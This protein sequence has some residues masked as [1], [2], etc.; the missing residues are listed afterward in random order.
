MVV[1]RDLVLDSSRS[2]IELKHNYELSRF[3]SPYTAHHVPPLSCLEPSTPAAFRESTVTD[4]ADR[5]HRHVYAPNECL[6]SPEII[7][8]KIWL[9]MRQIEQD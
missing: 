5:S 9:M 3:N 6:I 7:R 1:P 8:N 2:C 4:H